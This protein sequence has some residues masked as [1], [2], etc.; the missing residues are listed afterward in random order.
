MQAPQ[1]SERTERG[2]ERAHRSPAAIFG[3]QQISDLCDSE[4]EPSIGPRAL[5][6]FAEAGGEEI[7]V[8]QGFFERIKNSL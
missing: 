2:E 8:E 5:E 3:I 6:A 4:T 1:P 7:E